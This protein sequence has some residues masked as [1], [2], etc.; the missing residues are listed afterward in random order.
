LGRESLLVRREAVPPFWWAMPGDDVR[1]DCLDAACGAARWIVSRG[2][3]RHWS[4]RPDTPLEEEVDLYY[5]NAGAILFFEELAQSSSEHLY[6]ELALTGA[7]YVA[8]QV[9]KIAHSGLFHGLAGIAF[10]LHQMVRVDEEKALRGSLD[11][12]IVR[13]QTNATRGDRGVYWNESNDLVYGTAGIGLALIRLAKDTGRE[14]LLALSAAAGD[15][16]LVLARETADGSYWT[17]PDAR[18]TH[19]PNFSHG[20]AGIGY[21]LAELHLATHDERFLMSALSAGRFLRS[22]MSNTD[23]CESLIFHN[24]IAGRDLYY[25]GWCHGPAG[26]GRFLY[27][28]YQMSGDPD[29][30]ELVRRQAAALIV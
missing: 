21:F 2:N 15:N 18:S 12:V 8:A 1:A 9:E 17:F 24:D 22:M 4:S 26:T 28:L 10:A 19:Y 20:T 14:E 11:R 6:R 23:S 29:W 3:G 5:G 16:L 27:R 25:L 7:S 13:L 30:L